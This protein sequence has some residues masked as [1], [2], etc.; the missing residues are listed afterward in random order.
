MLRNLTV[1]VNTHSSCAD[2]WPMFFGQLK[3]HWPTHPPIVIGINACDLGWGPPQSVVDYRPARTFSS[4]YLMALCAVNT[5]YVLPLQDDFLLYG[6]VDEDAIVRSLK[7]MTQS[8]IQCTRLIRSGP[9]LVYSMQASLWCVG[10]LKEL[11]AYAVAA[12]PWECEQQV[13]MIARWDHKEFVRENLKIP[14]EAESGPKRGR[15]HWDS[16]VFPY[17][18]TALVKGKWNAEYRKE[19]EP[20]HERYG[21]DASQ[22]GWST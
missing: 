9:E 21:I 14:S 8:G 16:L 7:E 4:Q 11:Y 3:K 17:V 12:T 10:K 15:N 19:L 1:F 6:D 5:P 22:R 2:C 13:D 20:L 18:A